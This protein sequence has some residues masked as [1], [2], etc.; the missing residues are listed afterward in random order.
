MAN[1]KALIFGVLGQDGSFMAELLH[2]KGYEVYGVVGAHTDGSRYVEPHTK[3][4]IM[5]F[6]LN[7]LH[8][9]EELISL[10]R[11]DEIYNFA[12]VSNVFTP[13]D[14]LDTLFDTNVKLPQYI[15]EAIVKADKSIKFF[16][17][18]SCLIFGKDEF[19]IQNEQ[20]PVNPLHP[21][22]ISKY[23]AQS[24]VKMF[25]DTHG[26]FACSGI[27][28]NHESERRGENF[29]SKKMATS[30]SR[31]NLGSTSM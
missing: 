22:G 11:P 7:A 27:F 30:I 26:I 21:Y 19:G 12:G 6:K 24:L 16:Q 9:I 31:Y 2:S 20:T 18:S 5:I 15:L 29:F 4:M 14:D 3:G 13:W 8:H 23:A 25:R 1:K 28:F 10:V 17:A